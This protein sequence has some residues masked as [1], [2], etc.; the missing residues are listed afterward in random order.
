MLVGCGQKPQDANEPRGNFPVE[1]T[2]ASF[3]ATQQLTKTS[4]MR[5]TVRNAGSRAIPRLSVTI[6]MKG[7]KT[8]TA[9]FAQQSQQV[10][11]QSRSR[12]IW[13]VDR[14]PKGGE[15][16]FS[17]TW[18]T[19]SLPP[20]RSKTLS[21]AVTPVKPGVYTLSYRVAAGLY[22]KA[23]AVLQGGGVPE[24]TFPVKIS[25]APRQSRVAEDGSVRHDGTR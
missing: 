10:G 13:I 8:E 12:P 6:S 21:W 9:A 20:G 18:S 14:G 22:G 23:R 3:P 4:K 17:N 24:G 15:T 16:A 1:V 2:E 11:L 7:R 25:G 19:G 5:I